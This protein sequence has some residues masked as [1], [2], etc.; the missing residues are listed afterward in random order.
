EMLLSRNERYWP[1]FFGESDY[2]TDART[3]FGPVVE[4][5]LRPIKEALT[6]RYAREA[7]YPHNERELIRL[8]KG[9]GIAFDTFRDPWG[10]PYIASFL[11]E[12]QMDVL[13]ITSAG[14]DKQRGT[15]DDFTVARMSWPYFRRFG[16]AIGR[17]LEQYHSRTNAYIRDIATL[18]REL[19]REGVGLNRLRDPWGKPYIFEFGINNAYFTVNVKSAGPDGRFEIDSRHAGDDFIVWRAMIDSFQDTRAKLDDAISKYFRAA[20]RVSG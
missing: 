11:V 12:R 16:E 7:E 8:L 10:T 13:E 17:A 6:Q 20:S 1:G 19:L 3:V 15:A 4:A 14:A 2:E 9:F 18:K 5:Q